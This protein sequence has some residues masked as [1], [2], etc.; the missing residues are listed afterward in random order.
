MI[1]L[2]LIS[3]AL[4]GLGIGTGAVLL[5]AAAVIAIAAIARRRTP[6]RH[7]HLAATPGAATPTMSDAATTAHP[8]PSRREPAL[9]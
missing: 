3:M 5:L 9:R 8:E 4:A 6:L 1:D 2:H 7:G